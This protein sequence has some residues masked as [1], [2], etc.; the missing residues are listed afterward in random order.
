V[1]SGRAGRDAKLR[2]HIGGRKMR[3]LAE[4]GRNAVPHPGHRGRT[5]HAGPFR[6]SHALGHAGGGADRR[7]LDGLRRSDA[8][9]Q[10]DEADRGDRE[11]TVHCERDQVRRGAGLAVAVSV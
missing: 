2:G 10:F 11:Q 4:D 9:S 1:A 7:D 5:G 6:D 3:P 8:A